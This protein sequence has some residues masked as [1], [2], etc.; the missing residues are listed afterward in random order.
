M[1]I[2]DS[3]YDGAYGHRLG[4]GF[5]KNQWRNSKEWEHILTLIDFRVNQLVTFAKQQDCLG[6]VEFGD[7]AATEDREGLIRVWGANSMNWK[8]ASWGGGQAKV[9]GQG[10]NQFGIVTTPL[11]D[12]RVGSIQDLLQT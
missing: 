11:I 4:T 6:S 8:D 10:P 3:F 12:P 2:R 7:I 9:V 1:C 5:A